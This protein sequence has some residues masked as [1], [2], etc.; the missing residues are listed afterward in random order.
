MRCLNANVN[1]PAHMLSP[2]L[3]DLVVLAKHVRKS[4]LRFDRHQAP[5]L[6]TQLHNLQAAAAAIRKCLWWRWLDLGPFEEIQHGNWQ[7]DNNSNATTT[8]LTMMR[9][10]DS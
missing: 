9:L 10:D 6:V 5:F 1:S 4:R 3:C 7:Q 8:M 2:E